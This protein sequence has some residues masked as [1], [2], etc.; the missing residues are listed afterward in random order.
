[1]WS[2]NAIMMRK[3]LSVIFIVG[4]FF[5][6]LP[7]QAEAALQ[8]GFYQKNG[9]QLSVKDV[10]RRFSTYDVIF[11]GEYHDNTW[12]H[13]QE[14]E[15]LKA[16]YKEKPNLILSL[17][18]FE[19]DVQPYLDKYLTNQISEKDFLENSRPWKNYIEDYKPCIEFA[20]NK[21]IAV[22]GGNIPRYLAAE[23]AK[24]GTLY[25]IEEI[26]K[27]YLPSKHIVNHDAY[28]AAFVSYMKSG[29]VGMRLDDAQIE[30]YYQA[31][32][33][34]DDAMAES[35][36]EALKRNKGKTIL[37]LQGEFHGRN[38]LG[39]VEKVR[40]LNPNLRT[41][42]ITSVYVSSEAE[43]NLAIQNLADGDIALI[44]QK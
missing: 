25:S 39:V 3:W 2:S 19:R 11:F 28:Y 12:I 4:V 7:M 26:K 20:K 13:E 16:L 32:C 44:V 23:Y 40:L 27:K 9:E 37:H 6:S 31:Q 15:F 8:D 30:R 33:L 36:V 34:K 14:N 41:G 24:S 22:L 35:I 42:L 43:K 18:M 29:Q 10:A 5:I 17:E 1:M 21:Q 38:R